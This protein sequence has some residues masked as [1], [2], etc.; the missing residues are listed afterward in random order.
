MLDENVYL[1]NVYTCW[2]WKCILRSCIQ[3]SPNNSFLIQYNNVCIVSYEMT[4]QWV[5]V[6]NFN[7]CK[8]IILAFHWLV[9]IT[10]SGK[11]RN[12]PSFITQIQ[13]N[14]SDIWIP[15]ILLKQWVHDKTRISSIELLQISSFCSSVCFMIE[16]LCI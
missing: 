6:L 14:S 16:I 4:Y 12:Y 1:W 7:I 8:V 5:I 9:P 10:T 15:G 13:G 2:R 3:S 11:L